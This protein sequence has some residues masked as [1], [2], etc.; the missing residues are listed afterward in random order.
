LFIKNYFF[1]AFK[2]N[3]SDDKKFDLILECRN[4]DLLNA[5]DIQGKAILNVSD[6]E[7]DKQRKWIDLSGGWAKNGQIDLEI[8]WKT[9]GPDSSTFSRRPVTHQSKRR[10]NNE[11]SEISSSQNQDDLYV[12]YSPG[13]RAVSAGYS[14]GRTRKSKRRESSSP[15]KFNETVKRDRELYICVYLLQYL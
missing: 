5:D 9:S 13:K 10:K 8:L 15:D 11:E 4:E 2:F 14:M 3:V 7:N 6:F 12:D 1:T